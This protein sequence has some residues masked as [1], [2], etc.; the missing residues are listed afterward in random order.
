MAKKSILIIGSG[1]R[2]HAL[3]WKIK[4]SPQVAKIYFAPG[5]AGTEEV[6]ENINIEA[7]NISQLLTFAKKNKI[8]LT[9]VGPEVP[10]AFGIVDQFQKNG[11]KIFGPTKKASL[12]EASKAFAGSFL[13]KYKIPHPISLTFLQLQKALDFVRQSSWS[14]FVV[15]A[16]GLAAG[17]GVIVCHSKKQAIKAIKD[18]MIKKEFGS[19]GKKIIIQ[20]FLVGQELSILAFSDGKTIIP[21]LPTQ[22][23]KPVFDADRGPNTGGMGAYSPVPFVKKKLME[24]IIKTILQP[25]IAG[26]KKEGTPYVGVLYA[27]LMLTKNGPKVLEFN[28]RF[29]DPE[30][31]PILM[32]LQTDLVKIIL[33]CLQGNLRKQK[34]KFKKGFSVCVVLTSH[35][36]PG[37]YTKGEIISGLDITPEESVQIFHSGTKKINAKIVASGGRVLAVTALGKTI[38]IAIKKAYN[39]I[40][41]EGV[42]FNKMHYRKDIGQKAIKYDLPN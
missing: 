3:G 30:T 9:V 29:G 28:C 14:N 33:N 19:A 38:P 2:E 16:N 21:L 12:L 23:H 7:V 40:G 15:K 41:K 34:I 27:G 22:D 39:L 6:G 35:G 36:Y 37:H 4:Q 24:K 20:E 13:E 17:K 31:Q 11:L 42:H 8:D 5:N 10:L 32:L 1:G 25:T 26:M 18:L